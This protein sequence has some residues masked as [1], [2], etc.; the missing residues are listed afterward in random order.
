MINVWG[1][2]SIQTYINFGLRKGLRT[3]PLRDLEIS[4]FVCVYILKMGWAVH[5]AG[6]RDRR[7]RTGF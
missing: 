7:A 4:V 2:V 1:A 6:L 3:E 5:V